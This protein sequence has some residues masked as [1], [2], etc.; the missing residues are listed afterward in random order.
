MILLNVPSNKPLNFYLT[1]EDYC[2]KTIGTQELFFTW[3]VTP[4]II[5]GIHQ[6]IHSEVNLQVC[7]QRGISIFQRKSG[8][9]CVYADEGNLMLSFIT[10][11]THSENVFQKMLQF[12]TE[13]L[14]GLALPAVTT[15]H[16]DI[17]VD[18]RKVSGWACR[19]LP[20]A[21]IVHA[22]LLYNVDIN[23]MTEVL[24]PS[25]TKMERHC[26]QSVRQRVANLR[27]LL[28]PSTPIHSIENLKTYMENSCEK[29]RILTPKECIRIAYEAH[30]DYPP[31][32][33]PH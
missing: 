2:A 7:K 19:A 1:T 10:P 8:G 21:T 24:T 20:N 28:P 26:V 31:Y 18:E 25:V 14:R 11:N 12:V 22:T 33:Y 13:K 17:L 9:G 3:K 15:Q 29:Q 16:N 5:Y 6:D 27:G 23:T 30:R 4:T 32:E